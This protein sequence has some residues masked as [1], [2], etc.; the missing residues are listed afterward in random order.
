MQISTFHRIKWYRLLFVLAVTVLIADTVPH[1][2][3]SPGLLQSLTNRLA[4][5]PQPASSDYFSVH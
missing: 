1:P 5:E 3:L 2:N 4:S